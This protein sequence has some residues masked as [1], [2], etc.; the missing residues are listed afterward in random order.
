[1]FH[2]IFLHD[3]TKK[4]VYMEETLIRLEH[5]YEDA[6]RLYLEAEE[7][8]NETAYRRFLEAFEALKAFENAAE[9]APLTA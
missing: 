6:L 2:Y 3:I 8:E 1:M 7:G 4:A 5:A 9:E